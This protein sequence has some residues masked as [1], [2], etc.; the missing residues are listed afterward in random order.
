MQNNLGFRQ[1]HQRQNL[2]CP[3]F[4]N[5]GYWA[6]KFFVEEGARLVGVAEW[7]GSI[8][9]EE[10]IDPEKLNKFKL[11]NNGVTPIPRSQSFPN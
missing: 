9:N 5:V 4:G 7:D 11:E 6:S 10:G 3:K 1:T 8:Y 2:Y